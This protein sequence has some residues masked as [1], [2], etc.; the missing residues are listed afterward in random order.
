MR[1]IK[2]IFF[3]LFRDWKNKLIALL[4][5]VFI[6]YSVSEEITEER[7]FYQVPLVF[8]MPS[9]EKFKGVRAVWQDVKMVKVTLRG[10]KSRLAQVNYNGLFVYV[11]IPEAAQ[12]GSPFL[13]PILK[14]NVAVLP[15][16]VMCIKIEP[17]KVNFILSRIVK[18]RLEVDISNLR[19][20]SSFEVESYRPKRVLVKGPEYILNQISQRPLRVLA[21][22]ISGISSTSGQR[23][24]ELP[25]EIPREYRHEVECDQ[26]V[27]LVL[28]RRQKLP[29]PQRVAI[30]IRILISDNFSDYVRRKAPPALTK[31]AVF[32]VELLKKTAYLT[33]QGPRPEMEKVLKHPQKYIDCYIRPEN[34]APDVLDWSEPSFRVVPSVGAREPSPIVTSLRVYL[35]RGLKKVRIL[36]VKPLQ[37]EFYIVKRERSVK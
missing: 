11:H 6:W 4:I 20:P 29:P 5:A 7:V 30:P 12:I 28:R 15:E 35:D 1:K 34:L 8:K 14:E 32:S 27:E 24:L 36:K 37:V 16:G 2:N 21:T 10:S 18:R 3:F 33:L 22:A 23:I 17:S 25:V 13:M 19:L 9:A 31:D 26:E